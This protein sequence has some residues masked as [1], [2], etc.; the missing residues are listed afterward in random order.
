MPNNAISAANSHP[1]N[2]SALLVNHM[3]S[4]LTIQLTDPVSDMVPNIHL[5]TLILGHC[6]GCQIVVVAGR[7][8]R[9]HACDCHVAS[10]PHITW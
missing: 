10:R 1:G 7:M 6:K 9:C 3:A 2:L 8:L 4:N 5:G